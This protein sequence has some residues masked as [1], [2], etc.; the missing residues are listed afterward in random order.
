MGD[1]LEAVVLLL[2]PDAG[3]RH[4][5]IA[6]REGTFRPLVGSARARFIEGPPAIE[7]GCSGLV[8]IEMESA[9]DFELAAGA[10]VPIVEENRII[11]LL[12]VCRRFKMVA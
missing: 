4:E 8:V 6:P 3:G 10:E 5:P 9:S 11:G 1:F 12:T 7:P 2:P